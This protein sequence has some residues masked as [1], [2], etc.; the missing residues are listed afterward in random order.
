MFGSYVLIV[1]CV[2]VVNVVVLACLLVSCVVLYAHVVFICFAMYC[3][4]QYNLFANSIAAASER[5]FD[6][7]HVAFHDM[8]ETITAASIANGEKFPFVTVKLFEIK[9]SQSRRRTGIEMFS[10]NLLVTAAQRPI[11]RAFV[12]LKGGWY[13]QSKSF[14]VN[15]ETNSLSSSSFAVNET[16]RNFIWKGADLGE[17][18]EESAPLLAPLWQMT[19]PPFSPSFISYDMLQEDYVQTLLPLMQQTR[20][21][22]MSA[23]N[24]TL[25]RLAGLAVTPQDHENF[26][27]KFVDTIPKNLTSYDHPHSVHLEPIFGELQN[28]EASIVGFLAFVVPWDRYLSD[29]LPLTVEGVV[30]V[31]RNT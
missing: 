12:D 18:V 29:L 13:E 27:D 21:G 10:V 31:L 26:H 6:E 20:E 2:V 4:P 24:P 17:P 19:P 22:L 8:A 11:W 14:V 9:A 28:P 16:V 3:D 15:D 25:G 7:I 30:A 5:H 1:V 23:L